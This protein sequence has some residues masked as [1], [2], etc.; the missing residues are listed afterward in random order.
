MANIFLHY[1]KITLPL[2]SVVLLCVWCVGDPFTRESVCD[3]TKISFWLCHPY[4]FLTLHFSPVVTS[5]TEVSV[6]IVHGGD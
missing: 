5:I 4:V 2:P 1:Y 6:F 3:F